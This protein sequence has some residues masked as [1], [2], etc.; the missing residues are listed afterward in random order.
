MN[1]FANQIKILILIF[2][3][4]FFLPKVATLFYLFN[5]KTQTYNSFITHLNILR[6]VRTKITRKNYKSSSFY[7]LRHESMQSNITTN[8]KEKE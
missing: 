7:S 2:L 1:R 4:I 3:T 6:I 8:I 5:G